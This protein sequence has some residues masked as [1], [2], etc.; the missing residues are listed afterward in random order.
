M[1]TNIRNTIYS[2]LLLLVLWMGLRPVTAYAQDDFHI[3]PNSLPNTNTLANVTLPKVP[4][5]SLPLWD[6]NFVGGLNGN[7]A[8]YSNWSQGGVS[9]LALTASTLFKA[10]YYS[11]WIGY[12]L[13]VNL[14]YGQTRLPGNDIRKTD[15]IININNQ[16][17]YFFT[18]DHLSFFGAVDFLSQFDKGYKY[19]DNAPNVLISNFLAPAYITESTGLAYSPVEFLS[20]QGGFALKQTVVKDTSLSLRYGL[21]RGRKFRSEG[22]ISTAINVNLEIM[23]NVSLTTS[24]TS[25]TSFLK[26]LSSTDFSLNNELTGKINNF[27]NANLQF[28]M[29]YNDDI[30]KALQIKQVLSLGFNITIL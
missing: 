8:A 14:K 26:P 28:A 22:G 7:Q 24:F 4:P 30:T 29:V 20:V 11:K 25:F 21:Q 16:F 18:Q 5:D 3:S 12:K 23:K 2:S 13:L 19:N 6:V 10:N 1:T 17:N 27:I 15:D 9:S